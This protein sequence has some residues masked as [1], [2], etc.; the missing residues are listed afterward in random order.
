[1]TAASRKPSRR[2]WRQCQGRRSPGWQSR[3]E[4]EGITGRPADGLRNRVRNGSDRKS[5]NSAFR[6]TNPKQI[7]QEDLQP[8]HAG[9]TS[10][11]Q[12]K[13]TG[14]NDHRQDG[15]A[16]HSDRD[17]V[18]PFPL[19]T[20]TWLSIRRRGPS[21]TS[22]DPILALLIRGSGHVVLKPD[23]SSPAGWRCSVVRGCRFCRHRRPR[24]RSM[25]CLRRS[26]STSAGRVP[27]LV[28]DGQRQASGFRRV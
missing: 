13:V 11:V 26:P 23:K 2:P 15:E 27:A 18:R 6:D 25:R 22:T 24:K 21:R 17:S 8:A 4:L 14:S 1:M 3:L 9:P 5:T 12:T 28:R 10:P 16:E 7:E 20:S 19:G